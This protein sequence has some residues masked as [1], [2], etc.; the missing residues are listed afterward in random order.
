MSRC[1]D[2]HIL[3]CLGPWVVAIL[4]P[5]HDV[6]GCHSVQ[7]RVI[8]GAGLSTLMATD[9]NTTLGCASSNTVHIIRIIERRSRELRRDEGVRLAVRCPRQKLLIFEELS[10]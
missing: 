1:C 3:A 6:H 2:F 9:G 10:L 8:E 5:E 7:Q 4:C